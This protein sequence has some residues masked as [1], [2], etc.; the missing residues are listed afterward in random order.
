[1]PKRSPR[2]P[3]SVRLFALYLVRNGSAGRECHGFFFLES[4]QNNRDKVCVFGLY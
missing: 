4:K 3:F 1:M 2:Q